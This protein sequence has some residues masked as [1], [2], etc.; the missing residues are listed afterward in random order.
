MRLALLL[1]LL[2]LTGCATEDPGVAAARME[3]QD[4]ASCR[5]LSVGKGA[6]AYPQC[7]QNLIGYRQQAQAQARADSAARSQAIA[8]F[9]EVLSA[10]GDAMRASSPSRRMDDD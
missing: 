9:G 1:S 8:K 3:A 4:D 6:E 7:R 2:L 5:N 10:T